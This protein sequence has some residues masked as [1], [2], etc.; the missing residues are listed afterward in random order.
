MFRA[1][2]IQMGIHVILVRRKRQVP[3]LFSIFEIDGEDRRLPH[4][5]RP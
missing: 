1:E 2:I 5:R 4:R 3:R